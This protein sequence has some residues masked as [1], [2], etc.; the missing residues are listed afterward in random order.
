MGM[1]L[2]PKSEIDRV[3]A[4]EQR[5]DVEEGVKLARR[6][7]ALREVVAQE[8]ANL[9]EFRRKTVERI[10]GEIS[11]SIEER[12]KARSEASFWR[13]ERAKAQKPL[14]EEWAHLRSEQ[15][16]FASQREEAA[17]RE[18][19]LLHREQ[20]VA[21]AEKRAADLHRAADGR[22][23][24]SRTRLYEAARAHEEAQ[25]ALSAAQRHSQEIE[26]IKNELRGTLTH[27]EQLVAQREANATIKENELAAERK[28]LED[29]WLLLKD[30]ENMLTRSIQNLKK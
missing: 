3:Q 27:R 17:A 9:E 13:D 24:D 8:E 30:R 1:R 15:S 23:A 6:I 11:Q 14:D 19:S 2:L 18:S 29:G 7:D 10:H 20:S 28:K 4:E 25:S 22:D 12:D 26:T 21:D 5:R 16:S